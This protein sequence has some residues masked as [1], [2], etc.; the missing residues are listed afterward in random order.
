MGS[1]GVDQETTATEVLSVDRDDPADDAIGRAAEILKSGGVVAIPTETV[2]GLAACA[3]DP[4]AVSRIF[5]AKGRPPTNPLIV[6]VEGAEGARAVTAAWP[7]DADELASRFWPGPLTLVLPRASTVPSIVTAGLDTVAVRAPAHPVAQAVIRRAGP[8]AA[9]SANR[10]T[11]ISPTTAAHVLANLRGRIPLILDAGPTEVGIESTVL[12][13][14][15]ERPAILR[16]GAVTRRDLTD[17]LGE[18]DVMEVATSADEAKPSP[19]TGERHYAPRAEVV[20]VDRG[21]LRDLKRALHDAERPG[22][23]LHTMDPPPETEH[24]R[25]ADDPE[26]YAQELYAALHALDERCDRIVIERVPDT[27][28]WRAVADRLTRASR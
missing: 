15:G 14:I 23:L 12:S 1:T 7:D 5:E 18:V 26:K 13:L 20:L 27:E 11:T 22:A 28:A 2:Y 16:P 8:L 17:V 6:H 21:S 4:S 19:G 25:L 24:R 3:H 9:P 10:S